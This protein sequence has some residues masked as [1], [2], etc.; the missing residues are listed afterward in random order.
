MSDKT[1]NNKA[2]S[3]LLWSG[4]E[5]FG[6]QGLSLIITIVISRL[7]SPEDYG[8]IAMLS[9]FMVLSQVFINCGFSNYLIQNKDRDAGDLST[10]FYLNVTVGL[11]C[12][13][14]LF[15]SAHAI[16]NF[17]NQPTLSSI[18][19]YYSLVLII[20]SLTLVQRAKLYID[21]KYRKLSLIT[22]ASLIIAGTTSIILAINGFGVWAL[23]AYQVL[24]NFL[25]S[26]IIWI[27]SDWHPIPTFSF[28]KAKKAFNFGGKLLGANLINNGVANLYTMVIGKKFQ[29]T[30]LGFY[31]RGQS[32][33]F[34]FPT[35]FSNMLQQAAYPVLC[36]LQA[37]TIELK[38]VFCKYL[39]MASMIAFPIMALL[40][41]ISEPLIR[42]LLTDRW[43]PAVPFL[44]ILSIGYM[45]DPIMRLN[46]IILTVTGKTQLSLYSEIIKKSVLVAL[47]FIT[48]PLG[49]IWVSISVIIYSICDLLIVSFFTKK[50]IPLSILEEIKILLP[51]LIFATIICCLTLLINCFLISSLIKIIIS[52]PTSMVIYIMLIKKFKPR[53]YNYIRDYFKNLICKKS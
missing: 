32:L 34:V 10:V 51:Y 25:I 29:A 43:L 13:L 45:F 1:T 6:S 49:I 18:I 33:A 3:S 2:T 46:S 9:I 36:E 4:I 35:N 16:A 48:L 37:D 19:K 40:F 14:I 28:S 27:T 30:E 24:L 52:V 11:I 21:F 17:Y 39:S 15:L 53:Q 47:L 8:L 22:I 12:Y 7:V 5:L 20:S 38:N 50:I 42:I 31:S 23:V 41:G 44:K 26:I